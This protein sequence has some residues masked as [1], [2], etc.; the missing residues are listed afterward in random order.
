M[1]IEK[2]EAIAYRD[3]RGIRGDL[4]AV[5][6]PKE[7]VFIHVG[8]VEGQEGYDPKQGFFVFPEGDFETVIDKRNL[9]VNDAS[10]LMSRR[11]HP[12][13]ATTLT[14]GINALAIGTGVGTGTTQ[15]PQAADPTLHTLR[16]EI[17]RKLV[18]SWTY[19]DINGNATAT[20]TNVLQ[21]TTTFTNA[22]GIPLTNG[23]AAIVE[24][25]LMGGDI[26]TAANNTIMYNMTTFPVWNYQS[27]QAL[28]VI[29]TLTF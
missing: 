28:T 8:P 9:I 27:G 24:M 22:D 4:V 20:P 21:I 17:Y 18:S 5:A 1:A 12:G 11:M 16:N 10:I 6:S 3:W 29:W 25:A 13:A 26:N 19:L 15:V 23:A 14:G 7:P 2:T